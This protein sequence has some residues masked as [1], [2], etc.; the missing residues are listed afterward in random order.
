MN[1]KLI[2]INQRIPLETLYVA[3]VSYLNGTYSDDYILEQL[4]LEFR[5]ENRLK[6]SLRIVN[7]IILRNPLNK[8]IEE[9]KEQIKLA[10]KKKNDRN[11]ILI[12]LLNSSFSFSFDTLRF[13]GKY[14]SVQDI[15]SRETIK[16]SLASVYGGNRATDNAIDSVIP[17]FIEASLIKKPTKGVY[18]RNSDFQISFTICKQIFIESFK[19]NNTLDNIQEYQLRD[20]YFQFLLF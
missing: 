2:D 8:F 13:L 6:K 9:N 5:G 17:M 20:P 4:K 1:H 19:T 3:L 7:K 10:I 12:A 14:L 16:K 15:V 11:M 18:Q